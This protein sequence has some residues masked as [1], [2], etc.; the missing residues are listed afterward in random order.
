[1]FIVFIFTNS[2]SLKS[3]V[4]LDKLFKDIRAYF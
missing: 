2:I 4:N 3:L 1:M